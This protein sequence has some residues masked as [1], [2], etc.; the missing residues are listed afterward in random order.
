M[1]SS[2]ITSGLADAPAAA[3]SYANLQLLGLASVGW[4]AGLVILRSRGR[5]SVRSSLAPSTKET[6]NATV[7]PTLETTITAMEL[8][9]R[10]GDFR[11]RIH[12][13][14]DT[15][16]GR[17]VAQYNRVLDEVNAQK[18][19]LKR[20]IEKRRSVAAA[21]T[22]SQS[23]FRRLLDA[24]GAGIYGVDIN[25]DCIFCNHTCVTLL[26]C[27]NEVELI[28]EDM[29]KRLHHSAADGSPRRFDQSKIYRS[30]HD[31]EATHVDDE[32]I[33]RSNGTSFPAE[34]WATPIR[35]G[36]R[37]V[38][39]AITFTDISERKQ[40]E[41]EK[42][43]LEVEL[44]HSHK[45]EAVGTLAGGIAH[46][47]NNILGVVI[48]QT[49]LARKSRQ[50]QAD[51][52]LEAQLERILEASCS[53]K[54]VV[55]ELLTFGRR[56][57]TARKPVDISNAV[58]SAL[59]LVDATIPA[60]VEMRRDI[61]P[62]CGFI[63]TDEAHIHQIVMNLCTN[64]RHA[65]SETGSILEV[66]LE[67]VETP[68]I[69]ENSTASSTP[70]IRLRVRDNGC[71]I[72]QEI[73][74]QIFDPFFTTKPVGQGT[75]MGLA[76]VHGI[77][78]EH[79]GSVAVTSEAGTGTTVDVYLPTTS[80]TATSQVSSSNADDELNKPA[81]ILL[82][83]DEEA[84]ADSSHWLLI[85]LGHTPTTFTDSVAALAAFRAD[86]QAFDLVISDQAM[87]RLSG[88]E[89]TAQIHKIR[90]D[91]PIV[92]ASGYSEMVSEDSANDHGLS[93][94]LAK[95]YLEAELR[96]AITK[97]LGQATS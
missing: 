54:G 83:D 50:L 64:A 46:Y 15:D 33:W 29:H 92:L 25:G 35:E 20:E 32:V 43:R 74:P 66:T 31:G 72:S 80:A 36:D 95:P 24:T 53:A 14:P 16:I 17:I 52:G 4:L 78:S 69:K 7:A 2:L 26:G 86:P 56:S 23:Q 18:A 37:V 13:D 60:M 67:K 76:V 70:G 12:A 59:T 73:Q 84:L 68:A 85:A 81:R 77:V 63:E 6:D 55:G 34:Y 57:A 1:F 8:Q 90:H 5:G 44:R 97:A 93:G 9:R 11:R 94:Y 42:T 48:G 62:D 3:L 65:M 39:S 27:N 41:K 89:L 61:D 21:L 51:E 49:E 38:G 88:L 79:G 58:E 91:I 75:G 45:M 30:Y 87:P 10:T 47:F 22:H 82:V 71:G 28:G 40:V 96:D 19:A